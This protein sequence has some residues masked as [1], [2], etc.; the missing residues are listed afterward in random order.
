M[1]HIMA[2]T[3]KPKVDAVFEGRCKQT[4]RMGWKVEEGDHILFHEWLG[5]PY[6]SKWGRRLDVDIIH[7]NNCLLFEQYMSFP[8]PSPLAMHIPWESYDMKVIA[9]LDGIE[10][11]ALWPLGNTYKSVLKRLNGIKTFHG[12]KAQ[13][14]RW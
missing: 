10:G 14:I 3:Y 2:M 7:V 11:S 9:K 4:T 12:Q 6:H 5:K 13:I 1:K 8:N